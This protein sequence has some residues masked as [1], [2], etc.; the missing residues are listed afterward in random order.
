[1]LKRARLDEQVGSR[2][3]EEALIAGW[4]RPKAAAR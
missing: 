3:E 1:M 4:L 2:E